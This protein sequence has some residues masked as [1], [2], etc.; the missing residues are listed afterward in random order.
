MTRKDFACP[1]IET[2]LTRL[3][4][5]EHPILLA[6]MGS[7]AG[8][9]L[10]AA[11]TNA[12]GLGLIGSGYAN[13]D[14]IR[15]ELAE[16]GNARVGIG[17]ITWALEKN[18][19]ALDVA[20]DARP[21]AVM[22]SFGD[23][24]PFTGRIKD[25][26]CKDHLPGADLDAGQGSRRRGRRYHHRAGTRRRRPFGDDARHHGTCPGRGRRRRSN[27][28]G[29]RRRHRRWPWPRRGARIGRGRRLDGH[30]LHRI[31]RVAVGR[32]P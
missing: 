27:P 9:R 15:N 11:V 23:P 4:G 1:V 26:G 10:A 17:F 20:L 13:A 16:A 24:T 32:R 7:A 22:L 21:A 6:P 5:I 28:R 3:L 14:T 12:G 25:A 30:A 2:A 31:T 19:S 8:G 18:P 29:R